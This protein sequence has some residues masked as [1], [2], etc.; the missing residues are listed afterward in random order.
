MDYAV[1]FEYK[2]S[3]SSRMDN[4]STNWLFTYA[5]LEPGVTPA[6]IEAQLPDF[7]ER[8]TGEAW[9]HFSIQPLLDIH[10]RSTQTLD[11][12]PQG[13]LTI[14]L[15]FL[16]IALL[17]LII[18]AVNFMNMA[19]AQA[20]RRVREIRMRKVLGAQRIQLITQF[21]AETF[22]L[23][24]LAGIL[25]MLATVLLSP[26]LAQIT[27]KEL[28]AADLFQPTF[29][30]LFLGG[31]VSTSNAVRKLPGDAAFRS[32]EGSRREYPGPGTASRPGP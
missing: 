27:G 30:V 9:T 1:P 10:L 26:S 12:E 24:V 29:L 7:F 4:W 18:A 21:L 23:V 11:I 17:V 5:L 15:S 20:F 31:V 25:G 2:A 16:S 19:T 14:V 3:R 28:S 32:H 22:I 13:N 8:H 6:S